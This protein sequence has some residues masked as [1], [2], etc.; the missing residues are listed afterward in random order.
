MCC[1][2][3]T[4]LRRKINQNKPNK[5]R[6]YTKRGIIRKMDKP[7]LKLNLTKFEQIDIIGTFERNFA[8]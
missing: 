5:A 8:K 1:I 6:S 4:V 3:I 2:S 7:A